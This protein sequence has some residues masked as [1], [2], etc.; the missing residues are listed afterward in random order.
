[1]FPDLSDMSVQSGGLLKEDERRAQRRAGLVRMA[2]GIILYAVILA[3]ASGLPP[4]ETVVQRQVEAG[5]VFLLAFGLSGIVVYLL[6]RRD[7][8]TDILPYVTVV[9][10]AAI[11]LG[12]LAYNHFTTGIPGN[13]T[14]VFP[15]IWIVPI[16]LAA[17]AIY[18]RPRLQIFATAIY[19][20]GIPTI[21]L[22][23][24]YVSGE[25]RA[26]AVLPLLTSLGRDPNAVRLA[27]L[28]AAGLV[29][30]L[31]AFQGRRLLEQAVQETALRLNLTR[32]LP[33]EL[34]P[35]LSDDSFA[36][37]RAGR[38]MP[39]AL[40]FV[41]IRGSTAMG[42]TMD[43][44]ALARF[45]TAFRRRVARAAAQHGG[46]IDKFVGDGALVV[47][48][49]PRPD[50]GDSARAL[51]CAR[52]LAALVERWNAKRGFDPPVVVGIGVH[53][54]EVFCGVLGDEDRL[55]FTVLGDPVNIASRLEGATK[56]LGGP[57]L[58]SG[59]VVD[60]AGE[61]RACWRE[62]SSEP[63]RGVGRSIAILA[64]LTDATVA[65]TARVA[66]PAA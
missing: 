39:V 46:V 40:L 63:L 5:K 56:A 3:A 41:D 37:L 24:G 6:A 23:A 12:N 42:S 48:G 54:G 45:V 9:F 55:E 4:E 66:R 22:A 47:F 8:G 32:Y 51:A 35:V 25:A 58:A 53:W 62:V 21:S 27:M 10:D 16:A 36:E 64:P 18:F 17:N 28:V 38:R 31:A 61:D 50:E 7:V 15:V 33:R 26:E 2:L 14:F 60:A 20:V 11:I 30:I 43:P 57:I 34:A 1:M 44:A 65:G 59:D 19:L 52:T 29:L 49:V 13:M